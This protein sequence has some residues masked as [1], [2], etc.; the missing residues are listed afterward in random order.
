M[1]E[2]KWRDSL[3]VGDVVEIHERGRTPYKAEVI[4]VTRKHIW[5]QHLR[6]CREDGVESGDGSAYNGIGTRRIKKPTTQAGQEA[7]A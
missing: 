5:T 4:R 1:G 7:P 3:S 2:Q 6:F